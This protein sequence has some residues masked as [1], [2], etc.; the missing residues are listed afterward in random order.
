MFSEHCLLPLPLPP[1]LEL[2]LSPLLL[3]LLLWCFKVCWI[4]LIVFEIFP[5]VSSIFLVLALIVNRNFSGLCETFVCHTILKY[6]FDWLW[7]HSATALKTSHIAQ[8]IFGYLFVFVF[9]LMEMEL[10]V[11]RLFF[12]LI[13][14]LSHTHTHTFRFHIFA[15]G[16]ILM[17]I[18]HALCVRLNDIEVYTHRDKNNHWHISRQWNIVANVNDFELQKH[19]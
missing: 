11:C 1:S 3:P 10:L 16:S 17:Y 18:V 15:S 13:P 12:S 7:C 2:L 9:A 8:D 19:V 14:F 5:F 4:H 6:A